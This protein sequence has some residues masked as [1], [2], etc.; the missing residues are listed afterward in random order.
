MSEE[1]HNEFKLN[2][3]PGD[4][5]PDIVLS[6]GKPAYWTRTNTVI[7]VVSILALVIIAVVVTAHMT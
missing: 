2:G 7:S 3:F 1:H 4:G 5:D 6:H